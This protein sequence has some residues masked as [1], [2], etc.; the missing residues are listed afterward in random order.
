MANTEPSSTGG[1]KLD[2]AFFASERQKT[3]KHSGSFFPGD[4]LTDGEPGHVLE[5]LVVVVLRVA[6]VQL[7]LGEVAS[8]ALE[9]AA[10][11]LAL[12]SAGANLDRDFR[13]IISGKLCQ[14]VPS[15]SIKKHP[16]CI[17]QLN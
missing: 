17:D 7:E 14:E 6:D 8:R 15:Q 10:A 13:E 4:E 2:T 3:T 12:A 5:G 1:L 9:A 16:S 11:V